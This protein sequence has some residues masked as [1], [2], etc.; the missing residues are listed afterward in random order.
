MQHL[1]LLF[2][3]LLRP[4][5]LSHRVERQK[6]MVKSQEEIYVRVWKVVLWLTY[7]YIRT[8][9]PR[10][11]LKLCKHIHELRIVETLIDVL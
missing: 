6:F 1:I 3:L 9:V 7:L 11:Y 8:L 2:R 10:F 5:D 4:W